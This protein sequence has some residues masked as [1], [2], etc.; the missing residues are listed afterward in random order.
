VVPQASHATIVSGA[1]KGAWH[2]WL[3]YA[4]LSGDA[5]SRIT[6]TA[7]HHTLSYV[8]QARS[9]PRPTSTR[10]NDVTTDSDDLARDFF[11]A[12]CPLA[13]HTGSLQQRLADAYAE[14][15]LQVMASE[16]PTE[17]QAAFREVEQW[18]T[19]PAVDG[20]DPLRAAAEQLNDEDAR[21]MIERIVVLFGP[22]AGLGQAQ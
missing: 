3:V 11:A 21:A 13:C 18:L 19:A 12:T 4:V 2:E 22:L 17:L 8:R 5:G 9:A 16:L 7:D 6:E 15:L 1:C 14:H 20:D 10:T